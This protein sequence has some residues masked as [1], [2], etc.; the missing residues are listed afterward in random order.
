[1]TPL[2]RDPSRVGA[3][4]VHGGTE[5]AAGQERDAPLKAN[6]FFVI[7]DQAWISAASFLF[8]I[9]VARVVPA[10]EFAVYTL[11]YT[12]ALFWMALSRTFVT[13][14][15]EVLGALDGRRAIERRI[16]SAVKLVA[17]CA[18][19]IFGF[20]ALIGVVY[21]PDI[22]LIA[23]LS[24]FVVLGCLHDVFRRRAYLLQSHRL[25]LALDVVAY[26]LPLALVT[27]A[28][29]TRAEPTAAMAFSLLAAGFVA[30][31]ALSASAGGFRAR[32]YRQDAGGLPSLVHTNWCSTKWVILSQVVYFGGSQLY[33][34]M[35]LQ[36]AGREHVAAFGAAVSILNVFNV[37][38]LSVQTGA[39]TKAARI[40]GT[41]GTGPLM[42]FLGQVAL[43][44]G[45]AAILLALLLALFADQGIDLV[46]SG[47]YPE[48]ASVLP[49]LA[50]VQVVSVLSV[51]SGI[52]CNVL[53]RNAGTFA[54]HLVGT[55]F[56][57][58]AGIWLVHEYQLIG[59]AWGLATATVLPILVQTAYLA[60]SI[61][62][63]R[64]RMA[65][66]KP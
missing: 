49:L 20:N 1:M 10:G 53:D 31:L 52:A 35:L 48:A 15:I 43:A 5:V 63:T 2:V 58:T 59:A 17:V 28:M 6:W 3:D 44:S 12:V 4:R 24:V 54:G 38:R 22:A 62:S 30:V 37:L 13:L 56:S 51:V 23:V 32:I 25:A 33:G 21:F 45:A 9:C 50:I 18:L 40:Y 60:F 34:F 27:A 66:G 29:L 57:L 26:G 46:F 11:A 42:G 19:P 36:H 64:S 39:Q 16:A 65:A 14:P 7:A 8:A 55:V 61:W 41:D 47:K